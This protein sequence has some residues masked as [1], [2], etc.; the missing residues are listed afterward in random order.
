MSKRVLAILVAALLA[1]GIFSAVAKAGVE[2]DFTFH[3]IM[4]PQTVTSEV[5]KFDFDVEALL[6]LNITLSGLTFSNSLSMG[7]AGL[8]YYIGDIET[9]LGAL[10]IKD[11]FVFARPYVGLCAGPGWFFY[12]PSKWWAAYCGWPVPKP[13]PIGPMMFVKKRAYAE[14]TIGGLTVTNLAMFEDIN[15]PPPYAEEWPDKDGDGLYEPEDQ[16]FR[17]GDIVGLSG[18]TVSGIKVTAK[19]GI[20]AD[21]RIRPAYYFFMGGKHYLYKQLEYTYNVI[22]KKIWW[23]TVCENEKLEFSKEYLAIEGIKISDILSLDVYSIVQFIPLNVFTAIE[24]TVQLFGVG[25]LYIWMDLV[26]PKDL[27]IETGTPTGNPIVILNVGPGLTV[28]WLDVNNEHWPSDAN[29]RVLVD[30]SMSLQNVNFA[31]YISILVGTGITYMHNEVDIP[32]SFPEPIGSLTIDVEWYRD[33]ATGHLKF[34][35]VD[36]GMTKSF[37]EHNEF[38]INAAFNEEG[39]YGIDISISVSFS[40]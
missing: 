2:G 4:W 27:V 28:A 38:G 23:E 11:E 39:L 40:L 30:T 19:T 24:S 8:E 36:F 15:F 22:K 5:D 33:T 32:I 13:V 37:G 20:C 35:D 10:T 26:T 16:E 21:W 3:I 29:D 17:F 1:V 34:E 9:I 6:N 7:I 25:Q 14:I 31:T 18:T 12:A